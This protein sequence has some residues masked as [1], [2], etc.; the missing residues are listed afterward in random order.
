MT[1]THDCPPGRTL[2]HHAGILPPHRGTSCG[3]VPQSQPKQRPDRRGGFIGVSQPG[4]GWRRR[5]TTTIS[6][7]IRPTSPVVSRAPGSRPACLAHRPGNLS[8]EIR[9]VTLYK[10]NENLNIVRNDSG[11]CRFA[12]GTDGGRGFTIRPRSATLVPQRYLIPA[13]PDLLKN[14]ER[15]ASVTRH[16]DAKTPPNENHDRE[17]HQ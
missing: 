9:G 5:A 17:D 12:Q 13:K 14:Q 7:A 8:R 16:T 15:L 3:S 11:A 4:S 1:A 10:S 2:H 6:P